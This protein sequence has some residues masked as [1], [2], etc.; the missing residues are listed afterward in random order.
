MPIILATQETEIRRITVQSQPR[1]NS[2]PDPI[3]EKKKNYKKRVGEVTQS[4]G[5][6]FKPQY[7]KKKS[8]TAIKSIMIIGKNMLTNNK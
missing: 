1:A 3:L 7:H 8:H 5:L 6:E 2:L 4:V